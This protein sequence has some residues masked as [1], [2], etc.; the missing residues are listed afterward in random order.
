VSQPVL[1][2][3]A[4]DPLSGIDQIKT[5]Y[6]FDWGAVIS[7]TGP[8]A[9]PWGVHSVRWYSVDAAGNTET[10]RYG[11][12][13]GGPQPYISTPKG[14]SR[15][16]VKRSI[17]FSGKMSRAGNHTRLTLLAY[18][19]DG[20]NWVL[21]RVKSVQVHTPRR[22]LTTYR[23]AIKFTE[24]GTWQIVA[25]YEGDGYWVQTYSAPKYVIVR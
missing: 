7:Y 19:F 16:K 3:R 15:T 5:W 10:E 4:T 24:R 8:V 20:A 2:L 12:I 14:T 25:R 11:T 17:T 22:G 18:R 21:S 13:V 9:V 6:A 23:G 1:D